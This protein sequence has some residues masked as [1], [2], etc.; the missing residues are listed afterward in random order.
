MKS[1]RPHKAYPSQRAAL[2]VPEKEPE[3]LKLKRLQAQTIAM[4]KVYK[5]KAD[6]NPVLI[7]R[8][9]EGA[10]AA[11]HQCYLGI[12]AAVWSCQL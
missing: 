5:V 8:S 4:L 12:P 10:G 9:L 1:V 7:R 11:R 3:R 2:P 6:K